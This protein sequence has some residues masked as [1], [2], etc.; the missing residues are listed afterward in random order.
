[1]KKILAFALMLAL[2]LSCGAVA[3][4]AG[5]PRPHKKS[6]D[7]VVTS[8]PAANFELDLYDGT[9]NKIEEIEKYKIVYAP[10]GYAGFLL[11]ADREAFLNAYE[12]A[13]AVKDHIVKDFFWLDVKGDYEITEIPGWRWARGDDYTAG[14]RFFKTER[15]AK[16]YAETVVY[17]FN[18][19]IKAEVMKVEK[20]EVK[21]RKKG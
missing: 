4:A 21:T 7:G 16:R 10:V 3:F 11:K 2:V 12:D 13:K 17:P 1:M 19:N 14:V 15:G 6:Y 18:H 20:A 5:S 8:L 9:D